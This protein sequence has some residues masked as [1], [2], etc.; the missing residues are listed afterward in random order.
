MNTKTSLLALLFI[1]IAPIEVALGEG[2]SEQDTKRWIESKLRNETP[3]DISYLYEEE[4]PVRKTQKV[5]EWEWGE[6]RLRIVTIEKEYLGGDLSSTHRREY[7][8]PLERLTGVSAFGTLDDDETESGRRMLFQ[9]EIE[10][11]DGRY[12]ENDGAIAYNESRKGDDDFEA[13][14]KDKINFARIA[15]P[16]RRGK[17]LIPRLDKAFRH[18]GQIK[19]EDCAVKEVF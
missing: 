6:C 7:T 14:R 16:A 18:L 10:T 15:L 3:V 1:A 5:D 12:V 19:K 8:I 17:E 4:Y 2:P 11:D 13:S 9:A